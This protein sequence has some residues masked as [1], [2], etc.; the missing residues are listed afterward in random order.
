MKSSMPSNNGYYGNNNGWNH[1]Y[2]GTPTYRTWR[3]M[4]AR[5]L[6]VAH[7][8]FHRY[9]GQGIKVCKRWMLFANFLADMGARPEG[10]TL[11]RKNGKKGYSK[12]NCQWATK[13]M[14][15]NNMKT[16]KM[17][18]MKCK[19][20][21]RAEWCRELGISRALVEGRVKHGWPVIKALTLPVRQKR[22]HNLNGPFG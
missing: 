19:T 17:V 21:T 22:R 1:G 3:G 10:L 15:Q 4:K 20:Q 18:T 9:G 8:A 14:Q 11:D 2:H 16:N 13:L 12:S 7:T 5:C 6:N